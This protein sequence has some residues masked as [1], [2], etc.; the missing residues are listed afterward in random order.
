MTEARRADGAWLVVALVALTALPFEARWLDFELARRGLLLVVAAGLA[1]TS[2][3]WWP[4]QLPR[5]TMLFGALCVWFLVRSIAVTNTIEALLRT[6]YAAGLWLT[7]VWGATRPPAAL[8]R[9]ALAVGAIVSGYGILQFMGVEWPTGYAMT[10]AVSTLGNRNVASEFV[11]VCIAI[12]L[13]AATQGSLSIPGA[14]A[15]LPCAVYLGINGSRAG[16]LATA[17]VGLTALCASRAGRPVASITLAAALLGWLSASLPDDARPGGAETVVVEQPST[18]AV[19]QEIWSSCAT[20]VGD[21]PVFGHGT[22]QFRYEYPRYR[23]PEEIDLSSFGRQFATFVDTA[24][25][26]H[27]EVAVDGGVPA[28]LLWIAFWFVVIRPRELTRARAMQLLPV[29]AFL[30]LGCARSPLANAPTAML[31]FAWA[32]WLGHGRVDPDGAGSKHW[33][34]HAGGVIALF[35]GAL[36][37]FAQHQIANHFTTPQSDTGERFDTLTSAI[38]CHPSESRF[39]QLRVLEARRVEPDATKTLS[40]S[41]SDLESIARFDPNNTNA[42]FLTAEIAHQAGDDETTDLA[43]RRLLTI[44]PENPRGTLLA[45]TRLCTRKQVPRGIATLYARPHASLRRDLA[46]HLSDLGGAV[47]A[48]DPRG[49]ALLVLEANYIHALD[50]ILENPKSTRVIDASR[51]PAQIADD[52]VRVLYARQLQARGKVDAAEALVPDRPL[53]LSNAARRLLREVLAALRQLPK[54]REAIGD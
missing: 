2:R 46:S 7:F 50:S 29:L 27:I 1:L 47:H 4:A 52:R 23:S 25:N 9:A 51:M 44:D 41:R 42:L 13:V 24:H 30:I 40:A 34:I 48:S 16:L 6:A 18:I 10:Q 20:M 35:L 8:L 49:S 38:A 15:I 37:V 54:W 22:A 17:A 12:G 33:L 3:R 43:L 36:V 26:D 45:A 14:V 39:R 53:D 5:G 32:G 31:A 21:A 19:R 11:T 28:L